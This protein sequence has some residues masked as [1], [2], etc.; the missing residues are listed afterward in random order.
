MTAKVADIAIKGGVL[1]N[2]E[3]MKRWDIF[4]KDGLVDSIEPSES[5][6][7]AS[8]VIDAS[9]KFVL[10]GIIDA[11]NHPVYADRIDTLSQSAVYGGVT[12]IISYIGAIKAWGKT[13]DLLDAVKDFIEEGQRTS[14]IDFGLHCSVVASD[15]E[16]VSTVIPKVVELGVI[17]F[18]AFM[19]YAKR[20]MMLKDEELMKIME[21]IAENKALFAVHAESGTILD[22]LEDRFIAQG[23]L[24]PEFYYPSHPNIAEAE[25]IFR[26]L[27]LAKVMKC[28]FYIPHVS[29]Q[30]SLEVIRLFKKWGEP[31]LFTET[32]THYLT[33]TDEEIKKRGSL[34][35][36]GPP[37]REKED[38]EEM[39]RAVQE[40]LID[41]IASDAAGYTAKAKEPVWENVFKAGSGLP[42]VETMFTVVYDEG[43]NKGR[44][45]L[46]HL[47]KMTCENPARIFGLYPK[48]GVLEEGSDA[49]VVI[50]DP[51]ISHTIRAENQHLNVDYTMYEG[52]ECLG[53]PTLV[54]QRGKILLENGE[55]KA[56]P[57]QG[58]YLPG[59]ITDFS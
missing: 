29:A 1:V 33:L 18:K 34:G 36:V 46:P 57:G 43:V 45:T 20:G 27:T 10:P 58:K 40:G 44:I 49:D 6:K 8:R 21:I 26:I 17:S 50:F 11:H 48:K 47:V 59:K 19:A 3:E 14:A 53:A 2:S 24:G 9:G 42:G 32:C 38:V 41:V 51:T 15:M 55:L 23:N 7:T 25:A 30:E 31:S 5:T 4:I 39:W 28:S 16:T 12:T 52:R 35:K 22:Y 56:K 13:G 54:M 37:L